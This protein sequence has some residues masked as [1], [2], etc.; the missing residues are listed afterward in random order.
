MFCTNCGERL[1]DG[2][3]FCTNCGAA[4]G[5]PEGSGDA[6]SPDRAA[7]TTVMP[8]PVQPAPT[9]AMP[10]PRVAPAPDEAPDSAFAYEPDP[11]VAVPPAPAPA[12]A[13]VAPR[14]QGRGLAVF[15]GIMVA[16]A[17]LSVI[18]LVVVVVKPFGISLGGAP[19]EPAPQQQPADSAPSEPTSDNS[20]KQEAPAE[21]KEPAEPATPEEPAEP[22][23]TPE[24]PTEPEEPSEPEAPADPLADPAGYVL[25]DSATHLYTT[26]ELSGM[27]N[28][29]LY[30]ARNEIFARHGREFK[31]D[32]LKTYF[33]GKSWYTPTYSPSDFDA[34][35]T[36][37][38]NDTERK[39]A[40][41][42]LKIEQ[43]R[44]S[45]YL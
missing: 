36:S 13:D 37:L 20:D 40:E 17:I 6:A 10:Q 1:E 21:P 45:E 25:A 44:G 18:A 35:S 26:D 3:K 14:K 2:A 19:S 41:T 24:E 16:L 15:A 29:H 23:E 12:A 27:D 28:W 42:I 4:V 8:Q 5:G 34:Q 11:T 22:E 31:N 39:N 33:G 7:P 9:T 38:L 43:S 30:L 32:D